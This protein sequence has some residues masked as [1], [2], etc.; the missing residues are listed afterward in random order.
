MNVYAVKRGLA[1]L[2]APLALAGCTGMNNDYD[3]L[4]AQVTQHEQALQ[5]L[6]MQLSGVQPAQAD[7]WSQVQSM[8]QE[9][10][11][12]RGEVDTLSHSFNQAGGAQAMS[13]MLARHDRALRLIE[14]QLAM[15]LQLDDPAGPALPGAPAMPG[16]AGLPITAAP[17][18]AVPPAVT[19]S[20]PVRTPAAPAVKPGATDTA[21]A[22]YD[23]GMASFNNR[24][25]E[26]ALKAFTDFTSAYPQNKLVSN[27]WFWQG[28]SNY[29]MKNY[30]AA[31][32][33]YEKVI[34]GFPNSNKAPAS[35]LKQGLSFL[36]LGKKDAARER[37]SQL[38]K[39][40]PKA[41]EATRAR[42]EMQTNK[43]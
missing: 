28:E 42:Q 9:V 23:S 39:K 33:A 10:A 19:P 38:I 24:R 5:Q 25:Y 13:D 16:N 15:N 32:L 21:Q 1:L 31:A 12:L 2:L 11:S 35:Y 18:T 27:A 37:L 14:T 3:V 36:Q 20:T 43:L 40:Y 7:T 26:Q 22:L 6:N 34:S 41:P 29:Q 17:G 8:R 4:K 30:A